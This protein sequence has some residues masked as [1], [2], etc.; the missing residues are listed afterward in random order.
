MR[1]PEMKKKKKES[2]AAGKNV[3]DKIRRLL[4]N[5]NRCFVQY[6]YIREIPYEL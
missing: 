2:S 4:S 3:N 5:L 1:I 6:R